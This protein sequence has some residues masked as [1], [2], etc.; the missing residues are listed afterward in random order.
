MA[1]RFTQLDARDFGNGIG[2][3]GGLER[4]GQ[5]RIFHQRLRGEL[6]IDAGG[7]EEQEFVHAVLPRRVNDVGLH[8]EVLV[9]ELAR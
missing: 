7:T 8:H 5:Q 6:G 3:I 2:L 4:T 9:Q 1:V